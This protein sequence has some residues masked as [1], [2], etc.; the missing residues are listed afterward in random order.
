MTIFK[1]PMIESEQVTHSRYLNS[2]KTISLS[3]YSIAL[4]RSARPL[5]IQLQ[6]NEPTVWIL[7]E[8]IEAQPL[9]NMVFEF[10]GTGWPGIKVNGKAYLGTTQ[11]N[12][13][14]WHWFYYWEG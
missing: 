5:C 3:R 13:L 4:P 2:A 11:L 7:L 12:G 9:H 6:E 1:F 10:F 8:E 14:V